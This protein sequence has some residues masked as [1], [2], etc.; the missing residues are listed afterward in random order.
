MWCITKM[1]NVYK[2]HKQLA[3]TLWTLFKQVKIN[4]PKTGVREPAPGCSYPRWPLSRI[5]SS[6]DVQKH[7]VIILGYSQHDG[8]GRP[9]APSVASAAI[10]QKE[11]AAPVHS[12]H[13]FLMEMTAPCTHTHTQTMCGGNR[14]RLCSTKRR[15]DQW[16][17]SYTSQ[18]ETT[19]EKARGPG[20]KFF[21]FLLF[22]AI[23][24]ELLNQQA[25]TEWRK[26]MLHAQG[27][28][29]VRAEGNAFRNALR[30]V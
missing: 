14:S 23:C 25:P 30:Q 26:Q 29:E 6:H 19:N 13:S 3:V 17:C 5:S 28:R 10:S 27:L 16:E 7:W 1:V 24:P 8:W 9:C 22:K 21:F 20:Q 12:L 2:F 18:G 4:P 11:N 15:A